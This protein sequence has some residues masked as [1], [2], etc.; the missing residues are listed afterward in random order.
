MN[1]F[2]R[3]RRREIYFASSRRSRLAQD[4]YDELRTEPRN[5]DCQSQIRSAARAPSPAT[6]RS[7]TR[8]G[9]SG[10]DGIAEANP[11]LRIVRSRRRHSHCST[12]SFAR[13]GT[14]CPD[15]WLHLRRKLVEVRRRIVEASA[16][17]SRTQERLR[18]QPRQPRNHHRRTVIVFDNCRPMEDCHPGRDAQNELSSR[19]KARDLGLCGQ[20]M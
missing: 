18:S 6:A 16:I 10:K 20:K 9:A 8:P 4:D 17:A 19:V 5:Q 2:G 1:V 14:E 7:R 13:D 11:W 12:K 3:F 15:P